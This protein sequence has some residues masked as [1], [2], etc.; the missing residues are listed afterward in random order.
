MTSVTH[1]LSWDE[2]ESLTIIVA[3]FRQ[4]N[5]WHE[6]FLPIRCQNV[7][8]GFSDGRS[9]YLQKYFLVSTWWSVET[10]LTNSKGI[11]LCYFFKLAKNILHNSWSNLFANILWRKIF[12]LQIILHSNVNLRIGMFFKLRVAKFLQIS[13]I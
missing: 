5:N 2:H 13:T 7:Q 6:I 8:T 4:S 12:R 9:N 10:F 1:S 3:I 11:L